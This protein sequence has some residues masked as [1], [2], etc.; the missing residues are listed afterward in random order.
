MLYQYTLLRSAQ[1]EYEKSVLWYLERSEQAAEGFI[2]AFENAC[3]LIC[4]EPAMWRNEFK[5]Y[6][7][8]KLKKYPFSIIYKIDDKAHQINIYSIYHHSRNPKRKYTNRK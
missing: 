6:Y 3:L 1:E 4:A 7:E 2:E 8:L 5:Q